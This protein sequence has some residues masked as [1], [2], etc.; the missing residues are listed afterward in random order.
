MSLSAWDKSIAMI[1]QSI[2]NI[3]D[4]HKGE[5]ICITVVTW[6]VMF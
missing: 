3:L 1:R 6:I 5:I 2:C 4:G